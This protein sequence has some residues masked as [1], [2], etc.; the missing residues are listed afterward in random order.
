MANEA[1]IPQGGAYDLEAQLLQLLAGNRLRDV[2]I[3]EA[4]NG[5]DDG[6]AILVFG[7][8]Q[9]DQPIER[10]LEP[11]CLIQCGD[12][13]IRVPSHTDVA[14]RVITALS[15]SIINVVAA[16]EG[17]RRERRTPGDALPSC[18]AINIY[19]DIHTVLSRAMKLLGHDAYRV[20]M[21]LY[22]RTNDLVHKVGT[23]MGHLFHIANLCRKCPRCRVSSEHNGKP[24]IW[25]LTFIEFAPYVGVAVH[26]DVAM[27][28]RAWLVIG[29]YRL[30]FP[31]EL[32]HKIM[33][34]IPLE[35]VLDAHSFKSFTAQ[36]HRVCNP[37][38]F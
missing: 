27:A 28:R 35:V 25:G 14:K 5:Q 6:N 9:P 38:A 22:A 29:R 12:T 31:P 23:L 1:P 37:R 18:S 3:G 19:W 21:E 13:S 30:G 2:F 34:L 17:D 36:V 26:A 15:E 32:V 4:M 33:L 8:A 10:V 24:I 16:L 20:N 7:R 11:F